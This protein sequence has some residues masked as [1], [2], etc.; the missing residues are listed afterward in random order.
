MQTELF[1]QYEEDEQILSVSQ[2][3]QDVRKSL[4][5]KFSQIWIRGEISN[6]R[7]HSSGHRYFL[8]KDKSAQLKAVLFRGDASGLAYLPKEGDEC[9]VFGDVTVYELRGEYQI[10]VK[11]ILQDGLGNLRMQFEHLK[12]KLL[13]EGLFEEEKK[14]ALPKFAVNIGIVTSSEGAALQ[15]F[16]SILKRRGW[17]G[18]IFVFGSNVQGQHAPEELICA[19]AKAAEFPGIELIVLA[20]GGGSVEDLWSFNNEQLIRAVFACPIPT[21]SAIGH[22]TDFVLTD[23]VADFRAETP[24]AAAE[25]ISS[26][27][28]LLNDKYQELEKKLIDLP[29]KEFKQKKERLELF[30]ARLSVSSPISQIER[31]HQHMDEL[32]TRA[33]TTLKHQLER[34]ND[35]LESLEKRLIGCSLNS[36]LKKGFAYFQNNEGKILDSA[37]SLVPGEKVSATFIDGSRKLKVDP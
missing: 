12:Q 7:A 5:K 4:E 20:R 14:Q 37:Q 31:H 1:E 19:L 2:L 30:S 33:H 22:Q 13:A 6:L 9:L 3:T 17:K 10:R 23:F 28:L 18:N 16:I 32:E 26:E 24:S 27:F 36:A 35:S 15:D 8:L 21:I 11:H 25:W 34:I 29:S